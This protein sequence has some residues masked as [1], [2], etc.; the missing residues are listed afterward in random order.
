MRVF[1]LLLGRTDQL[2]TIKDDVNCTFFIDAFYKG[3]GI[4][5]YP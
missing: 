4:S 5:F 3:E 2:F 1:F